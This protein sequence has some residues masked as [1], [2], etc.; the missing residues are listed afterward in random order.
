[1]VK[2]F[3][4]FDFIVWQ[5]QGYR[6][7]LKLNCRPLASLH[8]KLLLKN[9]RGL[10]L[11]SLPHFLYKF[12]RKI[13]LFLYSRHWPNFI[14]WLPLLCDIFGNTCI[15]IICKPGCDVTNFEVKLIFLIKLFF[16]H[17]QKVETKT[18]ISWERKQFLI[19]YKKHF[20]PLL[21][22]FQPSN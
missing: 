3:I 19:W 7:I 1:M 16:L 14:V 21:N 10:E 12:W 2:S 8:I 22:G 15:T 6:N 11:V 18:K 20:S 4:Q 5:V 13:F 9:K 17:D